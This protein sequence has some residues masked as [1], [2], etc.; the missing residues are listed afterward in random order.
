MEDTQHY[1]YHTISKCELTYLISLFPNLFPPL[2]KKKK[3]KGK[4]KAIHFL[5]DVKSA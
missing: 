5:E 3:K 4:K 2:T 1:L